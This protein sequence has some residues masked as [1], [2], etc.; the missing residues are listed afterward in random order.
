VS[1]ALIRHVLVPGLEAFRFGSWLSRLK[2]GLATILF[3]SSLKLVTGLDGFENSLV[4]AS[5]SRCPQSLQMSQ[6]RAAASTNTD[7]RRTRRDI[8]C[9]FPFWVFCDDRLFFHDN[10]LTAGAEATK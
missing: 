6:R 2:G 9:I 5:V 7:A 10:F 1:I 4:S 8:V 3:G